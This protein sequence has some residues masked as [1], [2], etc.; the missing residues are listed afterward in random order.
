M[1]VA[2]YDASVPVFLRYLGQLAQLLRL[3]QRHDNAA[4]LLDARLAP[5]MHSFASQVAIAASFPL[6]VCLPLA[7]RA[8]PSDG[9]TPASFEVLHERVAQA[10]A[11]LALLPRSDFDGADQRVIESRAGEALV[12]LPGPAFLFQY[13][14][15]N[16]FFHL[17]AAY[18]ILRH[19][20]VALGKEDFDGWHV[21][22]R[23]SA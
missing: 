7:G 1:T 9:P 22:P 13:A 6:R 4:S 17:T 16:F 8:V 20:G 15:P 23:V 21:Y 19:H 10:A 18:A 11:A 5:D 14:L 2:L 3:A 12:S